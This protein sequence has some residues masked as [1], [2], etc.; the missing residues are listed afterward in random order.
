MTTEFVPVS[1]TRRTGSP[2]AV[3]FIHGLNGDK[4]NTWR[5]AQTDATLPAMLAREP[6]LSNAELFYYGYPTGIIEYGHYNFVSHAKVLHTMIQAEVPGRDLI[7]VAHSMGGLIVRQYIVDRFDEQQEAPLKRVKGAI[8]LAVP[9]QGSRL[10]GILPRWIVNKQI[11]S[12]HRK[13][14]ALARLDELWR[15]YVDRGGD[16]SRPRNLRHAIRNIT[17]YGKRDKVVPE[18]SASPLY[19]DAERHAVDEGHKSICKMEQ[20]HPT[21]KLL[22]RYIHEL[23]APTKQSAMVLHV[24][25]YEKRQYG[26]QANESLDWTRYFSVHPKRLPSSEQWSELAGELD[27]VAAHWSERWAAQSRRLQLYTKISLP[28]GILLGS[29]FSRPKNVVIE[30]DHYDELWSSEHAEPGYAV[31]PQYT[32]S[33]NRDDERA[34]IVL[35]IRDDIER[36]VLQYLQRSGISYRCVAHLLPP[37]GPGELGVANAGQAVAFARAVKEAASELVKDGARQIHLFMN[38]PLSV[39]TFIGHELTAVCPVHVYDYAAPDYVPAFVV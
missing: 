28:G 38:G 22:K 24:H 32:R 37:G 19:L 5:K 11:Q 16:P 2:V 1:K 17:F 14:P 15:V 12:L 29:R 7:F 39:A 25:G 34:V 8:Y 21:Y 23:T 13:S 9:F 31:V 18:S 26:Q 30:V 35:S 6:E 3:I 20:E 4:E 10:A 33:G 36:G 27:Q